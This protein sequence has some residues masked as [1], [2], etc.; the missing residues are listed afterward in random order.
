VKSLLNLAAA[1]AAV[2]VIAGAAAVAG[3]GGTAHADAPFDFGAGLSIDLGQSPNFDLSGL[4]QVGNLEPAPA[5]APPEAAVE[6]PAPVSTG[7]DTGA[8]APA[9]E[10]V[11]SGSTAPR[12]VLLPNTGTGGASGGSSPLLALAL[13]G[14]GVACVGAA[15]FKSRAAD[16]RT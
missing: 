11:P 4:T 12:T 1:V 14:A 7:T 15:A 2:A 13:A 8:G 5:A 16:V 10:T 9:A 3:E 6:V